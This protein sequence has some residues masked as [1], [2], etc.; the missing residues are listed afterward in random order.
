MDVLK[1]W[2]G[3]EWVN[4]SSSAS[5]SV[6]YETTITTTWIG[7]SAPYYQD[8]IISGLLVTDN[9]IVDIILSGVYVTDVQIIANWNYIY[10]II[11]E[12]GYVRVYSH[13]KIIIPIN[14]QI[15]VV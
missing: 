11:V 2:N 8:I 15:K 9:P 14:I 1:R 3:S 5:S 7:T 6:T 13:E 4:T 10:R 12:N